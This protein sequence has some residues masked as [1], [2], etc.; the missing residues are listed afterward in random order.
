MCA[1]EVWGMC[2]CQV[3]VEGA[4]WSTFAPLFASGLLPFGQLLIEMHYKDVPTTFDF[5]H[6]MEKAGY[7]VRP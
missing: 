4:E 3:D 2:G 1:D 7:R 5:F 6:N